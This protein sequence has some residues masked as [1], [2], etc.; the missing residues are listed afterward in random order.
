M[1]TKFNNPD[2]L[3]QAYP[4]MFATYL[5]D[6]AFYRGWFPEF[7]LLCTSIDEVLGI[8]KRGFKWT[9]IK[10]KFGEM[11]C[12]FQFQNRQEADASLLQKIDELID[13]TLERCANQCVV[14]GADAEIGEHRGLYACYC[15]VHANMV[16]RNQQ[17]PVHRWSM[18]SGARTCWTK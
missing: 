5:A 14:C 7:A 8:K 10:Q 6:I 11:R 12:Y 15:A 1:T 3:V 13:A 9:Q 18:Q 4:Y 16:Q 2:E 17:L